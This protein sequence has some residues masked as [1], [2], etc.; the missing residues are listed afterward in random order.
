M[1]P[2]VDPFLVRSSLQCVAETLDYLCVSLVPCFDLAWSSRTVNLLDD[3]FERSLASA[4]GHWRVWNGNFVRELQAGTS[5]L[6]HC[7]I[8]TDFSLR[9]LRQRKLNCSFVWP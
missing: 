4:A 9:F 3:D 6:F 5:S 2:K 8:S 1:L 7:L